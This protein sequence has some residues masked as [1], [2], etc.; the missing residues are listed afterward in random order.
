MDVTREFVSI[1][2]RIFH[3]DTSQEA[4][5]SRE[6]STK[7][8]VFSFGVVIWEIFE[9]REVKIEKWSFDIS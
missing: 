6:Y 9:V 2:M 5:R 8:D 3:S 1:Q 7:S 4:I